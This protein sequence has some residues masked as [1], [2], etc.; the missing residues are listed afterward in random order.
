MNATTLSTGLGKVLSAPTS[1]FNIVGVW[2]FA[3]SSGCSYFKDSCYDARFFSI[4]HIS[5]FP[6]WLLAH[7][8]L[9][10]KCLIVGVCG[11][12]SLLASAPTDGRMNEAIAAY[13][14]VSFWGSPW[15]IL[16]FI[17]HVQIPHTRDSY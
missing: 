7:Q 4:N 5:V 9:F 2:E 10:L 11:L 1:A 12:I 14:S 13:S 8:A 15:K 3:V 6:V 17:V 16:D